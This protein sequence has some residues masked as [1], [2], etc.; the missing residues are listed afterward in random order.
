VNLDRRDFL[1]LGCVAVALAASPG[2]RASPGLGPAT[3]SPRVACT[4]ALCRH[5][6]AT[7][8][9]GR[10]GLSFANPPIPESP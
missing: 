1:G 9:G 8:E 5:H 3:H 7:P 6:R 2:A 4:H 10:C